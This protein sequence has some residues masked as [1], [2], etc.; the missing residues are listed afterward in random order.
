[1]L[2]LT[3]Y[4]V[5]AIYPSLNSALQDLVF[6]LQKHQKQ[7][8]SL[9][10]LLPEKFVAYDACTA[11]EKNKVFSPLNEAFSFSFLCSILQNSIASLP[12]TYKFWS[13]NR[14][15]CKGEPPR[16]AIQT[17]NS[18]HSKSV[19][20]LVATMLMRFFSTLPVSTAKAERLFSKVTHTPSALQ[21]NMNED[22]LE[23]LVVIE[24]R[25][26]VFQAIR[27]FSTDLCS[28]VDL[29]PYS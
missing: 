12:N 4:K 9:S 16:T 11:E 23:A 24:R 8:L 7:A 10:L 3:Y 5:N 19:H 20:L 27:M 6:R 18:P 13:A 17:L 29:C 26:I 2:S 25:R 1:M 28:L 15:I 14:S 22:R 21:S